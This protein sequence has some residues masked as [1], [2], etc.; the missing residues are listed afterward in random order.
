MSEGA[1]AEARASPALEAKR[2]RGPGFKENS[3]PT[4]VRSGTNTAQ[5]LGGEHCRAPGQRAPAGTEG[6][7]PRRPPERRRSGTGGQRSAAGEGAAPAAAPGPGRAGLGRALTCHG[8]SPPG[9]VEPARRDLVVG[10]G[11]ARAA[12]GG[13][14]EAG[15]GRGERGGPGALS[16]PSPAAPPFRPGSASAAAA[17]GA[18]GAAS[19]SGA[20]AQGWCPAGKRAAGT[21]APQPGTRGG[22]GGR[23]SPTATGSSSLCRARPQSW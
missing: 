11:G 6:E 21:G 23:W 18:P 9:A 12:P 15:R 20:R 22:L 17:H 1:P 8:L 10:H 13:G 4:G 7:K 3:R 16:G 2:C 19:A 5:E 14:R